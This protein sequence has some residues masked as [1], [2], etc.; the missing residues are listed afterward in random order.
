MHSLVYWIN[1]CIVSGWRWCSHVNRINKSV[2]PTPT[3]LVCTYIVQN[4]LKFFLVKLNIQL[5]FLKQAYFLNKI[6]FPTFLFWKRVHLEFLILVLSKT[7]WSM[8]VF[9]NLS[10]RNVRF[11][12]VTELMF[13][14]QEWKR[15][16]SRLFPD[17]LKL[18]M[19]PMY[20]PISTDSRWGTG[21]RDSRK[22]VWVGWGRSHIIF[23]AVFHDLLSLRCSSEVSC[24]SGDP[25]RAVEYMLS[26]LK[27]RWGP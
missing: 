24:Q 3:H 11:W 15:I 8:L 26:S 22:R 27:K 12:P 16:F 1:Y 19:N 13:A 9:L 7:N 5:V 17:I 6:Y 4:C 2:T 25:W 10:I 18:W 14:E 23:T 21:Q 20:L